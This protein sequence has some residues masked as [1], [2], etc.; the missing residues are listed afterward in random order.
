MT[1]IDLAPL[2]SQVIWPALSVIALALAGYIAKKIANKADADTQEKTRK[3][4]NGVLQAG[5]QLAQRKVA[6]SNMENVDIQDG[7]VADA[8]KYAVANGPVALKALGVD[9]S[10]PEGR[11][12]VTQKIES[13]LAPAIMVAV[14]SKKSVSVATAASIV[15][16]TVPTGPSATVEADTSSISEVTAAAKPPINN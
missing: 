4:V 11:E 8:L 10:T 15:N 2:F 1:S 9:V 6:S 14:S 3:L 5:L 12:E 7:I 13:M 16:P